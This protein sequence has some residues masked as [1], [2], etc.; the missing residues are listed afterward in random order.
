MGKKL[1]LHDIM[2][3]LCSV[4]HERHSAN[5]EKHKAGGGDPMQFVAESLIPSKT[6]KKYGEDFL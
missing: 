3:Y 1:G 4:N 6:H 2:L 5:P